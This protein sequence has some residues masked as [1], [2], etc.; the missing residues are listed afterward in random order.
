MNRK[1]MLF[2]ALLV[3]GLLTVFSAVRKL[4][5]GDKGTSY[6]EIAVVDPPGGL[7]SFD[8]SWVDSASGTYYLADRQSPTTKPGTGRI[9]VV[10][11]ESDSLIGT[12]PGFVGNVGSG[13]SGPNGVVV[14]HERGE[15]GAGDGHDR[16][17]VWAGDGVDAG[18]HSTVKV[19]GVETLSIEDTIIIPGGKFRADELAYDPVDKIIMIANDRDTPAFVTFIS[20]E[21]PHKVLGQIFYDGVHAPLATDGLEQP[22]WD[23]QKHRLYFAVPATKDN[24]H[25]EV[26]EIDPVAET[27]TRMFPTSCNPAG[28]VLL[29]GQRLMTSCGDVLSAN[30]GEVIHTVPNVAGDEIWFNRGDDRVYFGHEPVFVVDAETYD[31]VATID[32]GGT[33]SVA[34]DS[35]NNHIF[36]PTN[37][38]P[39]TNPTA[40]TGITVWTADEDQDSDR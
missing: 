11:A 13:I 28:L 33:H 24:P 19:A 30:T 21:K 15:L 3:L 4:S 10:D 5:A 35:E 22:V 29:P 6:S 7:H 34:A 14:I 16:L 2:V 26:D 25:G 27:I 39:P 23:L 40:K 17:E 9:D 12:I 8:I 1:H 38:P 18:K 31:V 36:I 32:A 20:T 37:A